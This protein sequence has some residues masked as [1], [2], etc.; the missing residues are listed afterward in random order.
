MN[1]EVNCHRD[2]LL[3][4]FLKIIYFLHEIFI[5]DVMIKE[6]FSNNCAYDILCICIERTTARLLYYS[7]VVLQYSRYY[8]TGTWLVN[9]ESDLWLVAP[10]FALQS[11]ETRRY[12]ENSG[13]YVDISERWKG[14]GGVRGKGIA[15]R[16]FQPLL[17]GSK[18]C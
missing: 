4:Q 8:P 7:T 1:R 13:F 14:G 17:F 15:S 11:S 3:S 6:D 12:L 2:S 18:H 10:F 9:T 5:I 16:D